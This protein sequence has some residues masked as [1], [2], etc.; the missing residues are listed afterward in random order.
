MTATL[1]VTVLVSFFLAGGWRDACPCPGAPSSQAA[2]QAKAK[3]DPGPAA[4]V[5][6]NRAG[7]AE[8]GTLPGIGPARAD[9]IVRARARRPFARLSDLARVKGLGP[10]RVQALAGRV[11][12]EPPFPPEDS[13]PRVR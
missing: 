5:Q 13:V 12:F 9:A 7:P 8:L 2:L 11:G 6:V 4:V 10:K 1:L 3:P